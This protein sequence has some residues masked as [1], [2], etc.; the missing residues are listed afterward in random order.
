[1]QHSTHLPACT[2]PAPVAGRQGRL[3]LLL[4]QA[5]ADPWHQSRT[6]Q[7]PCPVHSPAAQHSTAQH[8][9][10]IDDSSSLGNTWLDCMMTGQ[11]LVQQQ[12]D[13]V[14]AGGSTMPCGLL[15][16]TCG[17]VALGAVCESSTNKSTKAACHWV[18]K[19][20]TL[21]ECLRLSHPVA[22]CLGSHVSAD[23]T[24]TCP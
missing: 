24:K 7:G 8:S 18:W 9:M 21:T 22:C 17:T 14:N 20:V 12:K 15:N 3:M 2:C 4:L 23:G 1:M 11:T 13:E 16:G 10:I 5:S 6:A 19:S